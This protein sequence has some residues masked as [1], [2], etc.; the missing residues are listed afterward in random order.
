MTAKT[1]LSRVV[2]A[3]PAKLWNAPNWEPLCSGL[4]D[5]FNGEKIHIYD[6]WNVSGGWKSLRGVESASRALTFLNKEFPNIR[7]NWGNDA[8]RGGITGK[9]FHITQRNFR[10][11]RFFKWLLNKDKFNM[12][13]EN[14]ETAI[15]EIDSLTDGELIEELEF[16]S[17]ILDGAK[18][19]AKKREFFNNYLMAV[20]AAAM[21]RGLVSAPKFDGFIKK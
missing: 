21:S 3:L 1:K 10:N 9:F 5:F 7:I 19:P 6:S 20:S 11:Y 4:A 13:L 15:T 17:A 18:L 16:I 8:P 14:I 12:I 2:A